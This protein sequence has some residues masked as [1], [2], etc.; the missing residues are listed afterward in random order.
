MGEVKFTAPT[1]NDLNT[2]FL[3]I[4]II[5]GKTDPDQFKTH[6]NIK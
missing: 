3:L 4:E 5:A 2:Q 6:V 1:L